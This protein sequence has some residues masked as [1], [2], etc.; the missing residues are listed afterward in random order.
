MNKQELIKKYRT[1][2]DAY[3][4]QYT[5]PGFKAKV[6]VAQVVYSCL[7]KDNILEKLEKEVERYKGLAKIS[8]TYNMHLRHI[9]VA[10]AEIQEVL[11]NA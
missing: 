10:Y 5:N 6:R 8:D 3:T 2:S 7:L 4:D 9:K 11:K 1:L